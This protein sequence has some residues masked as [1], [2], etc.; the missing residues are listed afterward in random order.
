MGPKLD[1]NIYTMEGILFEAVHP[2]SY[3]REAAAVRRQ[4]VEQASPPHSKQVQTGCRAS[5][6]CSLFLQI[7]VEACNV[8]EHLDS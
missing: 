3:A 8:G 6:T 1:G 5:A 7:A 4:G 2:I